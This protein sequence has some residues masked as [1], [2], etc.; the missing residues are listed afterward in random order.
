M[1]RDIHSNK[2]RVE[3]ALYDLEQSIKLCKKQKDK[4]LSLIVGYG[5]KSG[6]HKIKTAVLEKLEIYKEKGFVKD[7]IEGNKLDI[8]SLEYQKFKYGHLINEEEKRKKNPGII[9]IIC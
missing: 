1:I 7:Y 9:Y 2:E 5:S 8:F 4:V 6:H 3:D